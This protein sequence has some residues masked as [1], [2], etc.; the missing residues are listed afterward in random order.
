MLVLSI[1]LKTISNQIAL[2]H[3]N[4]Y[5]DIFLESFAI[6]LR[7]NFIDLNKPYALFPKFS[8]NGLMYG[9]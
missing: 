6:L 8:N 5:Q 2:T 1:T 4:L 9:G 7:Q 3:A